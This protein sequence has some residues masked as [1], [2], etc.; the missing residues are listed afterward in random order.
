MLAFLDVERF[1]RETPES[2]AVLAPGR[3]L[4]NYRD[5]SHRVASVTAALD[6]AGL[7]RDEALAL[8]SPNGPEFLLS[9]FGA[10]ALGAC[11]PLD[12][13]APESEY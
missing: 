10:S 1:S 7:L 6:S 11:A 13:G 9:L 12:P 2:P 4:L 3:P 5:L 8:V